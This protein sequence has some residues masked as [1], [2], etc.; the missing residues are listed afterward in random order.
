MEHGQSKYSR[1]TRNIAFVLLYR[2][3]TEAETKNR[4]PVEGLPFP[5]SE[6]PATYE[7]LTTRYCKGSALPT[8]MSSFLTLFGAQYVCTG[9]P[10]I[11]A[12]FGTGNTGVKK[13][14]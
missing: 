4:G 13:H 9:L 5:F 8:R 6:G 2:W 12:T 3:G 10:A 14:A 11:E 7:L 1:Q